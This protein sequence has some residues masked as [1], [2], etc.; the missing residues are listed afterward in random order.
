M[1]SSSNA[2]PDAQIRSACLPIFAQ[3]FCQIVTQGMQQTQSLRF[4]RFG[5]RERALMQIAAK[6][7]I[8]KVFI[9]VVAAR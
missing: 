5:R 1:A 3:M 7:G 2:L 8:H 9:A 6:A 4:L